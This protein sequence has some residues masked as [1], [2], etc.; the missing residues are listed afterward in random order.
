[1]NG[2]SKYAEYTVSELLGFR[3]LCQEDLTR[4][5]RSIGGVKLYRGKP[6]DAGNA[7]LLNETRKRMSALSMLD[8]DLEIELELRLESVIK[9]L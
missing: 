3:T 1:M 8:R 4:Q 9:N 5:S 6:I 2:L 7:H